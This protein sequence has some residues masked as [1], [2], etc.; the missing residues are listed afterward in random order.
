[1]SLINDAG[2]RTLLKSVQ[3]T[4]GGMWKEITITFGIPTVTS[5]DSFI[6]LELAAT[7]P[8]QTTIYMTGNRLN[9]GDFGLCYNSNSFSYSETARMKNDYAYITP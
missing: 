8:K 5:S 2:S 7:T 6:L 1:M 3:F 9:E 4:G